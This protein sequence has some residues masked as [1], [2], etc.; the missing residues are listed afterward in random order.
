MITVKWVKKK[1]KDSMIGKPTFSMKFKGKAR[2]KTMAHAS[3]IQV[4][5]DQSID[6]HLLFQCLLVLSQTTKLS[7]EDAMAYELNPYPAPL[8]SE[9]EMM[10]IPDKAALGHAILEYLKKSSAHFVSSISPQT[11][12]FV[13][14]VESLIHCTSVV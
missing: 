6:P 11:Y 10:R 14:D 1:V 13:L 9:R 12:H 2:A 7:L 8:F 3:A 5:K 4:G